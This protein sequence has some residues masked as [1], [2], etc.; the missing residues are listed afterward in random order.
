MHGNNQEKNTY[1]RKQ[2]LNTL[3]RM[4]KEQDF[5]SIVI[6]DLTK[7]AGVGRASFYRNYADKKDVLIQEA[8]RLH[9]EW[10]EQFESEEHTEANELLISLL[11]FYKAHSVF[12]LSLYDVGLT[13]II[14]DS[15]VDQK[16]ITPDMPNAIAYLQ[17][18]LAYMVYGWVIEWVKRGMMESGTELA[19][20]FAQTEKERMTK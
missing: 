5:D 20:M 18:S 6:S 2:I 3:L 12:Y 4:M 1:V 10:K 19:M 8:E 17:S 9:K 13:S 16:A 15:I 14:Q 7:Q 11:D